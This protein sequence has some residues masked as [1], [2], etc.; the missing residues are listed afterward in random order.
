MK[1]E[2]VYS[3]DTVK[4]IINPDSAPDWECN[5]F[6]G[7]ITTSS[8]E[9]D[10]ASLFVPL[11]GQ[12][13]GHEFIPDALEKGA[14]S[15]LCKKNHPL[16][17]KLSSPQRQKA[18]PVDDT[19][20]A[21]GKLAKFHRKRFNPTVI[22]ITGS[23]GKTTTKE[24][25]GQSL[26][27]IG[28]EYLVITEKNYNNEI[29]LPFTLFRIN[30]K[31]RIAV[32]EL[33]MNHLG[34]IQRLSE[35]AEPDISIVTNVGSAHI[36]HLGSLK[37]IA[38]A[39]SEILSGMKKNGILFLNSNMN[40]LKIFKTLAK[41]KSVTVKE[42][43]FNQKKILKVLKKKQTGF[44]L[45]IFEEK[46]DWKILG[47]KNVEN[48]NLILN[49]LNE[50]YFPKAQALAAL[51]NFRN[52]DKR[53]LI[54]KNIYTV[55]NDTYNANPE[56]MIS[57]IDSSRQLSENNELFAILGDMKELGKFSKHYHSETGKA[58]VEKKISGLI[59]FG[60]DSSYI[61]KEFQ[62][63][64]HHVFC[65]HF[66]DNPNSLETLIQFIKENI[67]KESIILVKGS[68]SMKMERITEA[69]ATLNF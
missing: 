26:A 32:C 5:F 43:S 38:R 2:F 36:A 3:L 24:L 10:N 23:S 37:N 25:L 69:L 53:F 51:K 7:N 28:Q 13:D 67:P 68:R 16:L 33:G 46:I 29:G 21:L 55:I 6:F 47:E 62:K 56:S 61:S 66:Q 27:G 1:T 42:V 22:A 50:I 12:R 48:L 35:M 58:C 49:V 4:K 11:K 17:K 34:E 44:E 57:S 31:T 54:E 63:Q 15:F 18:I 39:K 14:L 30:E 8:M 40:F 9:A 19:L 64:K 45:K 20:S 52:P 65:R 41:K 60:K 59:T